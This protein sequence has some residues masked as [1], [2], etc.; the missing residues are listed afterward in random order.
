MSKSLQP[1][2][3]TPHVTD[4]ETSPARDDDAAVRRSVER[5]ID[6]AKR[7]TRNLD[8]AG[9]DERDRAQFFFD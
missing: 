2:V 5:L 3:R 7:F 8:E 1:S 6:S 9:L 4:A